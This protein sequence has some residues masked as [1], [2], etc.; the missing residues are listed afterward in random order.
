MLV[1]ESGSALVVTQPAERDDPHES[2]S[3]KSGGVEAI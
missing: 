2:P 1:V 3:D